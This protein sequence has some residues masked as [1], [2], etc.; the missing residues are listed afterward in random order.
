MEL[1]S[2]EAVGAPLLEAFKTKLVGQPE[3]VAGS[4]AHDRDLE[5]DDL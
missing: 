2:L 5:L 4:P 3:L 1:T